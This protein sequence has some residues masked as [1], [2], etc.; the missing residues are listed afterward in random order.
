MH[1]PWR[2]KKFHSSGNSRW[3]TSRCEVWFASPRNGVVWEFEDRGILKSLHAIPWALVRLRVSDLTTP[4]RHPDALADV[5]HDR[6]IPKDPRGNYF[7]F[8]GLCNALW[9]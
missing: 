9:E 4:N 6:Q 8:M 1:V 5:I 3:K 7:V 2:I